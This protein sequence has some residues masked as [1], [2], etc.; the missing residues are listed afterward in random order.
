MKI[1][2]RG[3]RKDARSPSGGTPGRLWP[4]GMSERD[5]GVYRRL[6]CLGSGNKRQLLPFSSP[7]PAPTHL[8]GVRPWSCNMVMGTARPVLAFQISFRLDEVKHEVSAVDWKGLLHASLS[9]F[10]N[11]TKPNSGPDSGAGPCIYMDSE[12][13]IAFF[14]DIYLTFHWSLVT[15]SLFVFHSC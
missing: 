5:L 4:E 13:I 11:K 2:A 9:S 12:G 3:G 6:T 1:N 7:P 14:H 10:L 8:C 15:P